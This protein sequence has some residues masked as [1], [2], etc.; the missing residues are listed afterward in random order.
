VVARELRWL[1]LLACPRINSVVAPGHS[2][3]TLEWL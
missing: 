2:A 3:R 1:C